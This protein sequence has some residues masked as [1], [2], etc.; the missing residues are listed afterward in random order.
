MTKAS[1]SGRLS[2]VFKVFYWAAA[3][4]TLVMALLP[5]PPIPALLVGGDKVQ[6]VLAFVA[7]SLLASFAFPKRRP[8]E[9][10]LTLAGFGAAIEFLQMIPAL[11]RDAEV[12]DWI[13]DC[14]AIFIILFS[15]NIIKFVKK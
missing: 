13:A 8:I 11:N 10:F 5:H 2:G 1:K 3:L 9:L 15:I 6:H 4:F 7:L 14:V 12:R